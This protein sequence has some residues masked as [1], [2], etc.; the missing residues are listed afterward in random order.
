MAPTNRLVKSVAQYATKGDML[1]AAKAVHDEIKSAV[2]GRL[3]DVETELVLRL[4][5]SLDARV[6]KTLDSQLEKRLNALQTHYEKRLADTEARLLDAEVRN[7]DALRQIEQR[8]ERQLEQLQ[9]AHS[10]HVGFLLS[11][12]QAAL[13]Q[14]QTLLE[15]LVLPVPMVEVNVPEAAVT[16]NVP[17]GL[18]P[19]VNVAVPE[20][21]PPVVNVAMPEQPA[22][23]VTIKNA[24]PRLV[25]KS[26]S[27]DEFSRP[28]V[29]VEQDANE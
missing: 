8:H 17:Q 25:R 1:S 24:P 6:T 26:I 11:A 3:D 12:N 14:V 10:E 20:G 22:P 7:A 16:V 5:K 29:I 19:I 21:L 23:Q 27:Y 28:S 4:G 13:G 15:R 2:E 18:A 9:Q